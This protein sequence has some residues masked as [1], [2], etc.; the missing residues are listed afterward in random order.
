MDLLVIITPLPMQICRFS[1]HVVLK[2]QPFIGLLECI[3]KYFFPK[4][5]ISIS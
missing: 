3:F 2:F 1:F 4:E 5:G